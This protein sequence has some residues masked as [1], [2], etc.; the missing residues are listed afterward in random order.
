MPRVQSAG[1]FK[2]KLRYSIYLPE[3]IVLTIQKS[4]KREDIRGAS[5]NINQ[6]AVVGY[7]E[8]PALKHLRFQGIKD[9]AQEAYVEGTTSESVKETTAEPAEKLVAESPAEPYPS[10][11]TLDAN[12]DLEPVT[13]ENK[14]TDETE[15]NKG[16]DER[17]T[18][19]IP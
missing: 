12:S 8:P 9:S 10:Q 15:E 14:E 11:E 17:P 5:I 18:M 7:K 3:T 2:G 1:R 19:V 16:T 13:E 6:W 4:L